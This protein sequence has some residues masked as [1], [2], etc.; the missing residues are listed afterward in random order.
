LNCLPS[1]LGGH[2]AEAVDDRQPAIPRARDPVRRIAL[3]HAGRGLQNGRPFP[4]DEEYAMAI[5]TR[6]EGYHSVTPYLI[7][8]GAAQAIEFYARAFGATELFR[9]PMGDKVGHAEIMIGDSHVMLSDE[10]PDMN[11]R[12]PKSRGGPT[13]SLM[14]YVDDVDAMFQRAVAAG[15]T[16]ERGVENQFWGDRT[17][18]V[19]DPYGH[20]WMLATH[21]E[22][23]PPEELE[24]RMAEWSKQPA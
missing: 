16:V 3:G 14:V 5:Q 4:F 13:A 8:D 17:G 2:A 11:L 10:W 15:A 6:P 21:V 22:E 19:V 24:R 20:R 12:G 1:K 9:L 18:T 7:C 23:V